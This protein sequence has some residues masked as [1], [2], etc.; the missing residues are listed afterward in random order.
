MVRIGRHPFVS[1]GV[2]D[3]RGQPRECRDCP[4]PRDNEIH[5]M[6]EI[7][8]EQREAEERRLGERE[9]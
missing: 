6:P 5:D 3:W 2:T 7:P 9:E 1:S 4:L 8:P